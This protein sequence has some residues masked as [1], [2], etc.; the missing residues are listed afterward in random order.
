M[1]YKLDL[2]FT[3][4]VD[5]FP[6]IALS[7]SFPL[8]HAVKRVRVCACIEGSGDQTNSRLTLDGELRAINWT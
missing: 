4:A 8:A 3:V 1:D 6:V 5:G 2:T 7:P